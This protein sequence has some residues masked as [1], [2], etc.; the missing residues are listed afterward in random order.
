MHIRFTFPEFPTFASLYDRRDHVATH[1]KGG[2]VVKTL[3]KHVL[4][5]IPEHSHIKGVSVAGRRRA[6]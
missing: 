5:T 3:L 4:G 1:N 2:L 6:K